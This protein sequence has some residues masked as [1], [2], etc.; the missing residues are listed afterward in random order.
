M[1]PL[2]YIFQLSRKREERDT[3]KQ[4]IVE[5]ENDGGLEIGD[6]VFGL[7]PQTY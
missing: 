4:V 3:S 2:P 5:V 6:C 1:Y 7:V